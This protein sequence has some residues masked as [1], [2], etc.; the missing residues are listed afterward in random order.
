MAVGRRICGPRPV[1]LPTDSAVDADKFSFEEYRDSLFARD[2]VP[3]RD[4]VEPTVFTVGS[5]PVAG[6]RAAANH[7]FD[8]FGWRQ[9]VLRYGLHRVDGYVLEDDDGKAM[10]FEQPDGDPSAG[11]PASQEWADRCPLLDAEAQM[12]AI[13]IWN[14]SNAA[15]LSLAPSSRQSGDGA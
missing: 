9:S 11:K 15:P 3:L 1:I 8:S 13:I 5:L 12:L 6:K 10:A 14:L 7:E 2:K 4:G